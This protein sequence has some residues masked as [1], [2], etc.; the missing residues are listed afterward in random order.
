M[1][2]LRWRKLLRE[3]TAK[4]GRAEAGA[5]GAV[6]LGWGEAVVVEGRSAVLTVRWVGR[7]STVLTADALATDAGV[8]RRWIRGRLTSL[9]RKVA[10]KSDVSKMYKE[11]DKARSS[12]C[13]QQTLKEKF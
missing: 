1:Q 13:Q 6:G 5:V 7:R 12:P 8:H 2:L 11:I 4:V 3:G 10:T 9:N